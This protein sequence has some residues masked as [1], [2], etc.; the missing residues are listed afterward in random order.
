MRHKRTKVY[1]GELAMYKWHIRK[2]FL[3]R[4]CPAEKMEVDASMTAS[5]DVNYYKKKKR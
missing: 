5:K 3:V 1:I 4:S 2:S